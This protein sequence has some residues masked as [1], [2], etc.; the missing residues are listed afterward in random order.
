MMLALGPYI[1]TADERKQFGPLSQALS[2]HTKTSTDIQEE[3]GS[4]Q[5]QK[6][7]RFHQA[8]EHSKKHFDTAQS[9]KFAQVPS[10]RATFKA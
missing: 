6:F 10:P 9:E 4:E 7:V 5:Y 1:F 8:L 2:N 3:L